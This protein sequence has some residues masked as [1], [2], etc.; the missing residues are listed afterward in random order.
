MSKLNKW[1]FK[2]FN[3]N[4]RNFNYLKT[5]PFCTFSD[6]KNPNYDLIE[7]ILDY[8]K[9]D[10]NKF[11]NIGQKQAPFGVTVYPSDEKQYESLLNSCQFSFVFTSD[12]TETHFLIQSVL[13][14][15]VPICNFN[16]LYI[17]ALG[18]QRYA[19]RPDLLNVL[20]K[21]SEIM[22]YQH[23]YHYKTYW[24]SWKYNNQ[25]QKWRNIK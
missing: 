10:K 19:T 1:A 24:L 20:D 16:H 4:V 17:K 22:Y 13:A 3:R 2:G 23:I 6:Q 15:I 5:L 14:G 8:I 21:L 18:L 7:Q 9:F 12:I 25:I 11:I